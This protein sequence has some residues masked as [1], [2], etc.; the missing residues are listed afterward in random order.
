MFTHE[1]LKRLATVSGP[2]LTIFEPLRDN[3]SQVTKPG[4]RMVAAI[5]EA[6]RL[7]EENGFDADERED[8]LRPLTKLALNTDWTGRKGSF[9]MFRAP[10]FTLAS[11]W[12]DTCLR[13]CISR[14]SFW[15]C[16]CCRGF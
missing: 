15:C 7:L 6:A 12:P 1:D 10:D 5:Q 9:V 14:R 4:T 3:Y 8:I 2:C 13:A 11:F 16:R